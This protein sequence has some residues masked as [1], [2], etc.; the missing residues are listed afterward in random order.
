[1]VDE[2]RTRQ[3]HNR[4]RTRLKQLLQVMAQGE[5]VCADD[6]RRSAEMAR[7]PLPDDLAAALADIEGS[8]PVVWKP[9]CDAIEPPRVKSTPR[10]TPHVADRGEHG[11]SRSGRL[12]EARRAA[13]AAAIARFEAMER[14][15]TEPNEAHENVEV[16]QPPPPRSPP[17][18]HEAWAVTGPA[19]PRQQR[20]PRQQPPSPPPQ[21]QQQAAIAE[22]Q[23]AAVAREE[24]R[25]AAV[26][27]AAAA[28]AS[29]VSDE[30]LRAMHFEVREV[31]SRRFGAMSSSFRVLDR[32]RSGRLGRNELKRALRQIL[33]GRHVPERVLDALVD[34][35]DASGDGKVAYDEFAAMLTSNDI[36][37]LRTASRNGRPPPTPEV[38]AAQAAAAAVEQV[39]RVSDLEL[40]R[41]QRALEVRLLTNFKTIAA[42]FKHCDVDRSGTVTRDEMK[43]MLQKFNM[44]DISDRALD[45]IID[46]ADADRD[47]VIT[48]REFARVLTVPPN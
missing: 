16:P 21:P 5:T 39:R 37:Q 46:F 12:R 24:A 31:L 27:A 28:A 45:A 32:E 13:R 14:A 29:Q 36:V 3:A 35:A 17:Q 7:V 25:A 4:Q 9:V 1:M 6:L 40:R 18:P 8:R 23:T 15:K 19:D 43:L 2:A 11:G 48:F 26:A 33:N 30:E 44:S 10:V 42:A 20:Q 47:G 22:A 41:T 34:A 38:A